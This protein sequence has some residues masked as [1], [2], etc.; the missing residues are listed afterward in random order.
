MMSAEINSNGLTMREHF[1]CIVAEICLCVL[2][3]T[4]PTLP[5]AEKEGAKEKKTN[6][7]QTNA[8]RRSPAGQERAFD[9]ALSQQFQSLDVDT[10][11]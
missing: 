7:K 4:G 9:P 2:Q 10:I 3:E 8:R 1:N 5:A 11:V 6:K